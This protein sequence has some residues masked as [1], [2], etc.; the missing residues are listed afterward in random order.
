MWMMKSNNKILIK[1]IL[2]FLVCSFISFILLNMVKDSKIES[3]SKQ[4]LDE[5]TLK[6]NT[7][8]D[9][10]KNQS[11]MIFDIFITDP[12]SIF[13]LSNRDIDSIADLFIDYY[14]HKSYGIK[15]FRFLIKDDNSVYKFSSEKDS[16]SL[17]TLIT[18]N[19]SFVNKN[20][21]YLDGFEKLNNEFV[22][23]LIYPV[24]LDGIY[25]GALEISFDIDTL[26]K[27]FYKI[28]KINIELM[29]LDKLK[30][31]Y[32]FTT[33]QINEKVFTY[34][35]ESYR[36]LIT[37]FPLKN[38]SRSALVI[39][40]KDFLIEEAFLTH[41]I[42]LLTTLFLIL[43][44]CTI[45]YFETKSKKQLKYTN[46]KLELALDKFQHIFNYT[47]AGFLITDHNREIVDANPRF[48]KMF[49]YDNIEELIGRNTQMFHIDSEHFEEYGNLVYSNNMEKNILD[50]IVGMEYEFIKRGGDRIWCELLG[51]PLNDLAKLPHGGVLWTIIDITEKVNSKRIIEEQNKK[52]Q[53]L[54]INLNDEVKRQI[55]KIREKDSILIQQSKLASMGE[56]MDAVAHQWKQPL[57]IIKMSASELD[58]MIKDNDI[59]KNYFL[60]IS[61]RVSNQV[62]HMTETLDE[63]RSFF[64]PKVE[65]NTVLLKKVIDS[66]LILMKDEI[67]KHTIMIKFV[68]D[69]SLKVNVIPNEFKHVIIN[70]VNN[71]KDEFV[72]KDIKYRL[73]TFEVSRDEVFTI[74]KIKDT[75]GGIRKDII[76]E[77][78]KANFTTKQEDKGTGIGLYMSKNI[79]EKT[80]GSIEV[81]NIENGAQFIIRIPV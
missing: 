75:A 76:D 25:I 9:K 40:E 14:K 66:A 32:N 23:Q 33:T 13:F 12:L 72:S 81:E 80:G 46:E 11:D 78:F 5:Y 28:N 53:E 2:I 69:D 27:D 10:Y 35:E 39:K 61:K 15:H 58:Y 67:I 3:L 65:Y 70:I 36:N 59:D 8:I 51:S 57:N 21:I 45:I 29:K 42:I 73:I 22:Y 4:R 38:G 30:E 55:E 1:L 77:I 64:R 62:N 44:T 24:V 6:Y 71:A 7:T 34:Y 20:E 47:T 49:G 16:K 63:F 37:V 19:I 54:N 48:L 56:M 18:R 17:S 74:L 31:Q 60:D 68:G 52:L 79:I 26:L 50:D 43:L 41:K